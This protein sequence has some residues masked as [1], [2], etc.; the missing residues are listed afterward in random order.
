MVMVP[1]VGMARGPTG[2]RTLG[3]MNGTA[4]DV[5]GTGMFWGGGAGAGSGGDLVRSIT[6]LSR[7]W[8]STGSILSCSFKLNAE[9][10]KL[11]WLG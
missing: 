5:T 9:I 7:S 3:W 8:P 11:A 6:S 10:L 2:K 4:P 1:E